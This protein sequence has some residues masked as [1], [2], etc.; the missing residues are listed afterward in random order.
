M[1]CYKPLQAY[2]APGGI[3]FDVKKS[4]GKAH[5]I[6]L[7]CGRCIGCRLE[8]SKSWALRCMHEASM[9]EDN[10][11]ITLTLND[12]NLP[13]G[14]SLDKTHFPTFIRSLRKK[15][16]AKI[17]YYMCGE[18]GDKTERPHYHAI[19]FGYKFPDA[20]LWNI[21][22]GNRVY[23]SELLESTWTL[24]NSE[25]GSVT[26]QSAGY[27][28]RYLLKKQ[29]GEYGARHYAI[30]DPESGVLT[31]D[32]RVPEFTTMSL[33]PGIGKK[34]FLKHQGDVFP[35]DYCVA[36]DGRKIQTPKYYRELLAK[37]NP[38]LYESLK[39]TRIE[40]ARNNPDNTPDRLATR[41]KCQTIRASRLIRTH[42]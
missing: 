28:A 30:P 25:I 31:T 37:I 34:W 5:P 11:F 16:K 14:N 33:K 8:K 41:E 3:T 6:E 36:P 42:E 22:K 24:G 18:Y 1:P 15:T 38:D 7:P 21:R 2:H 26:M 40:K 20:T 10:V 12:E 17:R 32:L 13:F 35:H 27:V 9:F 23:R 39:S 4:F 19:L 29:N